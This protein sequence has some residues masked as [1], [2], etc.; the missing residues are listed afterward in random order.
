MGNEKDL[1]DKLSIEEMRQYLKDLKYVA[2]E[3]LKSFY[4]ICCSYPARN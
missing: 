2:R 4:A 1:T 3:S